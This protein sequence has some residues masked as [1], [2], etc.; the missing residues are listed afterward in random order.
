M[1][2]QPNDQQQGFDFEM[3]LALPNTG[4]TLIGTLRNM[5]VMLL[6]KNQ[7][8]V[9]AFIADNNGTSSTITNVVQT[10]T[11]VTITATN[12]FSAGQLVYIYGVG[13]SV[14]LN[15]NAYQIQTAS[16]AN[17][18]IT[19]S[20]PLSAYTSGGTATTATGTTMAIGEEIIFDCRAAQGKASNMGFP[21]GTS[22]YATA[23]G[24]TGNIKIS[25]IY[26]KG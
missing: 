17:F 7:T 19:T 24:G 25:L 12:T 4:P 6:F 26:S 3:S 23:S 16:G 10:G 20:V 2:N 5:P 11:S 9:P 8:T 15:G 13:G 1:S 14:Q 21:I 22:F 18:T